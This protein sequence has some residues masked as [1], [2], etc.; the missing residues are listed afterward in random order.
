MVDRDAFLSIA[1]FKSF[2][3][4]GGVWSLINAALRAQIQHWPAESRELAVVA[5]GWLTSCADRRIR[6]LSA[7]GLTR[8]IAF[9][10][11]LGRA[12]TD[13]FQECDDDY[14]LESIALAI[15]S[16][17]LLERERKD[18]FISALDGLLSPTFDSSNVLIRDSVRLLGRLMDSK[19][20]STAVIKRLNS[21]PSKVCTCTK[22]PVLADA[23]PLLGLDN[24]P[25]NMKLWGDG[26]QPDFWRYQVESEIRN[27][28]LDGAGISHENI[29]CWLM[30]EVLRLGYPGYK[31]C[32]LDA[33]R[34]IGSKF[35][36]GRGREGFADRLGKKYYWILLHRLL[37]LLADNIPLENRYSDWKVKPNHLWSVGIRKVDLTDV[38]DISPPREYPDEL[39]QDNRYSFPDRTGDIKQWVR[40]DDFPAH[41]ECIIRVSSTGT[42][43]VA[44]SL[45]ARDDDSPPG[46]KSWGTPYLGIRVFYTSI[47]VSGKVPAFGFGGRDAFDSQGA[48]CYQ[49]YLAEYPDSPVFDQLEDQGDFYRGPRRMDFSEVTLLRGGEWE[50]DFSFTTSE[51]QEHLH[52]PCQDVVK[53]LRLKW[54]RQRGWLDSD[55]E[56]I[57]F[58]SQARR[59]HGLF[60]RRD[61]LNSYLTSAKRKLVYRR[62]ANRGLFGSVGSN[63]VQIDIFTW[64]SYEPSMTP[65]VLNEQKQPFNC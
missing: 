17:C 26:M 40:T 30:M 33:D 22:W 7:K 59:Q 60:I 44:L 63:G 50:Y 47:F 27:F 1:A 11:N 64:L 45:S 58:E 37:G 19:K 16:A 25:L 36:T 8:L 56:L 5:L 20:L 29:A 6:D 3:A 10:P 65:R 15:Y 35:G 4:K 62:F 38:R 13:E 54:D 39:F 43:W 32:A 48:S 24:L 61:A 31:Q 42:E 55:G 23:K 21:Y 52:V 12:L 34:A 49:G 57:A 14:I 28:D 18:E 9:Q 46:E 2:D 51:R 53:V 41:G